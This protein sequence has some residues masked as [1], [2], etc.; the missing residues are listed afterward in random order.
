LRTREWARR[1]CDMLDGAEDAP[2][3]NELYK[4]IE[5]DEDDLIKDAFVQADRYM[6]QS[7]KDAMKWR[8]AYYHERGKVGDLQDEVSWLNAELHGAELEA[9]KVELGAVAMTEENM[10]AHGWVRE[11]TG[12]IKEDETGFLVCSE[13]GAIQPEEWTVYYCW[14]C[15]AKV[16]G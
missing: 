11:R 15:G 14:C 1:Y 8:M 13:C 6:D 12:R 3:V 9:R 16:V 7:M 4:A 2:T 10:A 5:M